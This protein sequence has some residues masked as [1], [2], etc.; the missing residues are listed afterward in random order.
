MRVY[1]YTSADNAIDD[2]KNS[3]IKVSVLDGV[4]DPNEWV[5]EVI[6]D[7]YDN[8]LQIDKVRS[9]VMAS[10]NVEWGFVS[11]CK[12]WNIAPMWGLYA[13]RF[14]GAVLEFDIADEMLTEVEYSPRRASCSRSI[15]DNPNRDEFKAMI[16]RKSTE[17]EYEQEIRYVVQ[18]LPRNCD[19][20]G[21][22][23]FI[24]IGASHKS[25]QGLH[26][27]GVRCG[28]LMSNQ[29]YGKMMFLLR[30]NKNVRLLKMK[31]S[32][33]TFAL[34]EDAELGQASI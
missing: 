2:I 14:R 20:S 5:P 13:D 28:P 6:L 34:K 4:N 1:Y 31:F 7:K 17:W 26:L 11:F 27:V 15:L 29:N 21:K 30:Q 8:R 10:F 22:H 12:S 16:S 24:R 23:Y 33:S 32:E 18:L 3:H 25:S 9:E 19:L